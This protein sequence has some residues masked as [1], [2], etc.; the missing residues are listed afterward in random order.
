MKYLKTFEYKHEENSFTPITLDQ[1]LVYLFGGTNRSLEGD[2]IDTFISRYWEPFTENEIDK[3]KDFLEEHDIEANYVP[4][5]SLRICLYKPSNLLYME[6][7]KLKD[8]WFYVRETKGMNR[9]YRCD[10]FDGLMECLYSIIKIK[11]K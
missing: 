1:L 3:I 2:S 11:S 9:C 7:F 8:E 10:Q 6:I 4:T 5:K